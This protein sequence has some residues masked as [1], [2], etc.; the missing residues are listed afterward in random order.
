MNKTTDKAISGKISSGMA[1][2]QFKEVLTRSSIKL[3]IDYNNEN[4]AKNQA[5]EFIIE[6]DLIKEFKIYCQRHQIK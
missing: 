6:M 5:Y 1:I 4:N 3:A 2:A